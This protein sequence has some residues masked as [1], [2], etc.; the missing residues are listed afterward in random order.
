M[1]VERAF[2]PEK[3]TDTTP[4]PVGPNP[5]PRL[6]RRTN[7]SERSWWLLLQVRNN[8]VSDL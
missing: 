5:E 3:G 6:N 2:Q 1:I 8:P 7:F 4:D